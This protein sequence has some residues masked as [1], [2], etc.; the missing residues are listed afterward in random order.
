MNVMIFGAGYYGRALK[1]YIE[2]STEY[3]LVAFLDNAAQKPSMEDAA[4]NPIPVYSPEDGV[5][6]SYDKI[7]ISNA[8]PSEIAEI[9]AQLIALGVLPEKV[10]AVFEDDSLGTTVVLQSGSLYDEECDPRVRWLR[11][12]AHYA[13]ELQME[14]NVAECGVAAGEFAYYINKYFPSKKLYLFDTFEGFDE[15]DLNVERGLNNEEFLNGMFNKSGMFFPINDRII[16]EHLVMK[17]M[18]HPE[19]CILKKGYFPDTAAGLEDTFCFVNLDMDLYQPMLAGLRFFYEK[20]CPGGVLLLH[21][22]FNP[23]LPGVQRAVADFEREHGPVSKVTIG[24]FGSIAIIK[25]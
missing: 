19:T 6:Q 2:Q 8:S 25:A 3:R 24:D 13:Q 4:G 23:E 12:F 1:K 17:R 9:K 11:D 16:N 15:N 18:R 7:M 20:M 10:Q 21:D 14:G 5:L 22:Y